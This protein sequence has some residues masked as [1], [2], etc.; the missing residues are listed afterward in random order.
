MSGGVVPRSWGCALEVTA[1]L[2]PT[3]WGEHQSLLPGAPHGIGCSVCLG[4]SGVSGGR[5]L[6]RDKCLAGSI[7]VLLG[8]FGDSG[9]SLLMGACRGQARQ[10]GGVQSGL[11]GGPEPF[12]SLSEPQLGVWISGE[13]LF[14]DSG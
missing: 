9:V 2:S 4:W 14:L 7:L 8:S 12:L 3:I 5:F 10:C 1:S 6:V 11:W 13:H